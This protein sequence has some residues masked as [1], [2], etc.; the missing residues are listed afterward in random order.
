M[1]YLVVIRRLGK[2]LRHVSTKAKGLTVFLTCSGGAAISTDVWII[3]WLWLGL[4][5]CSF[6]GVSMK[7]YHVEEGRGGVVIK[8]DSGIT[9]GGSSCRSCRNGAQGCCLP[10]VIFHVTL[11]HKHIA[12]AQACRIH[13]RVRLNAIIYALPRCIIRNARGTQLDLTSTVAAHLRTR[14]FWWSYLSSPYNQFPG[15]DFGCWI[16]YLHRLC[17]LLRVSTLSYIES[18][19]K[20]V[21]IPKPSIPGVIREISI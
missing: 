4:I 9:V 2:S 1:E 21:K 6:W 3:F 11:M 18:L 8:G 13:W 10:R 12:F 5:W 14:P 7:E 16:F 20:H 15:A 19:S 17:N